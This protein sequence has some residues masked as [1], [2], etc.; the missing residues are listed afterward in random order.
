MFTADNLGMVRGLENQLRRSEIRSL[1]DNLIWNGMAYG[2]PMANGGFYP[3]YDRNRKPMGRREATITYGA[4]GAGVGYGVSGNLRGTAIGAAGG[5]IVGLI[6]H[7]GDRNNNRHDN[8]NVVTPPAQSQQGVRRASDG[9]PIAIGTRLNRQ[10]PV[11]SPPSTAGEWRVTNRT[12]KRVEIWDGEQFIARIEPW[13][14]VQ[15]EAP[16]AGLKAVI[17]VPNRSGGITQEPA[18]IR[19]NDNFNGW[20]ILA[21]AVQ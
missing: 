21:P 6:T 11:S 3:M 13:Q 20:D 10:E 7:R 18:Q 1:R 16:E 14:S 5:A 12:S 8:G 15:V 9:T 19:A 17:L 2:L 4:I